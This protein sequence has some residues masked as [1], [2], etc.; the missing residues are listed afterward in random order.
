MSKLSQA[1]ERT[2]TIPADSATL[3]AIL[4]W[5][6]RPS[7]M[8][9]FVHGSGSG[10]LSPRNQAVAQQLRDAAL[11]TLLFDLLTEWEAQ[12]RNN[13]FDIDLLAE[14]LLAATMWLA[15]QNEAA[16]LPLGYLGA[17]TGAAAAL[18]AA[19]A[20]PIEI[21]AVVS[22]G[23]RPDLAWDALPR[24][25]APTLLLVGGEDPA[26]LELNRKALPRLRIDAE[27]IVIPG[28]SHL[29]EE[30]GT[31]EEV[32]RLAAS[33]LVQHLTAQSSAGQSR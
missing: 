5:P 8:V 6:D 24:V 19:A 28:A 9:L 3:S 7:G 17:S 10:R 22:R 32:G 20:S 23:G 16:G 31:L 12:D 25:R 27:L 29:F 26:V 1:G 15:R 21:A 4:T 18:K 14:R 2:A 33:W 13:V 11:G 30:P